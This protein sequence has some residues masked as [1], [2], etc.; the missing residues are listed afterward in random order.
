MP[1]FNVNVADHRNWIEFIHKKDEIVENK[2]KLTKL[3]ISLGGVG[4]EKNK[5]SVLLE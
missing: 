3:E 5:I 1:S 4:G 2:S